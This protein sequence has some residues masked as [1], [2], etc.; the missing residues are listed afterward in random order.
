MLKIT[1]KTIKKFIRLRSEL[2][3]DTNSEAASLFYPL[4]C[5][6]MKI[7]PSGNVNLYAQNQIVTVFFLV[8][9]CWILFV[10]S[11]CLTSLPGNK[12]GG[13]KPRH[14]PVKNKFGILVTDISTTCVVVIFRVKVCC[15][16]T[17][18][19]EALSRLI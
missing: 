17:L 18:R 9:L 15:V 1:S 19:A 14:R 5:W 7:Q 11:I 12:K 13:K 6:E 2:K 8:Q 10:F 4:T 16:S 3:T